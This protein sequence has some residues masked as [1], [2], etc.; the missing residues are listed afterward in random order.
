[1]L[2]F[3]DYN[4]SR[5]FPIVTISL[6]VLN[7]LVMLYMVGLDQQGAL[8]GFVYRASVIPLE[9]T[10]P[11]RI[12]HG[13]PPLDPVYLTIFTAMFMHAG[14]LHLLGNMLYLWIFGNNIEDIMG[15]G[16]FLIFYLL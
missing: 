13:I 7:A 8:Q 16:R 5:T 2:P 11:G 1:M 12:V 15:P 6:I 9:F 14:L 3:R 10:H 4:P